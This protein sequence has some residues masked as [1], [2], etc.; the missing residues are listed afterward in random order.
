MKKLFLLFFVL[1]LAIGLGFLIHKDPGYAMVSYQ[2]WV[3]ATSIWVA[4]A[5]LLLAFIVFYFLMRVIT[6]IFAIPK[7]LARRRKFLNAQKYRKYMMLGISMLANGNHK[8]AE[9]YFLK[10]KKCNL[11]SDEEFEQIKS[12]ELQSTPFEKGGR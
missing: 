10:L 9:K 4:A 3:I 11:I 7:M 8:K 2:H 12:V 6:N 5:C 1:L